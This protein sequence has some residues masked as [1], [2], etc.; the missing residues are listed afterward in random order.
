MEISLKKKTNSRFQ[1]KVLISFEK[2]IGCYFSCVNEETKDC[3]RKGNL[4]VLSLTTF[5]SR[6]RDLHED[7]SS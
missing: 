4:L 2:K 7:H 6:R 1:V 3:C 5:L